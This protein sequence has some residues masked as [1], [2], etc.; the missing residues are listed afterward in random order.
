MILESVSRKAYRVIINSDITSLFSLLVAQAE[1]E[2][3]VLH[4][5]RRIGNIFLWTSFEIER[6]VVC[7]LLNV[8]KA[9]YERYL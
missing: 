8:Y 5:K 4:I 2:N 7:S 6:Y 3:D 9:T 1:K